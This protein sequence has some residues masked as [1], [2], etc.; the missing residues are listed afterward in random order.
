KETLKA[1]YRCGAAFGDWVPLALQAQQRTIRRLD[2]SS[3]SACLHSVTRRLF[4]LKVLPVPHVSALPHTSLHGARPILHGGPATDTEFLPRRRLV[5]GISP[6]VALFQFP[7][8]DPISA[9]RIA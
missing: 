5:C 9:K 7:A 3:T 2:P 8:F 4:A 6:P 1:R